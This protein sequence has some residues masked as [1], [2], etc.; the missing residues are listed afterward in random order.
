MQQRKDKAALA[1]TQTEA[2]A[3]MYAADKQY[4]A[5]VDV[6]EMSNNHE[7]EKV[8]AKTESQQQIAEKKADLKDQESFA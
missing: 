3:Q 6:K 4:A 7:P 1:K 5:K 8:A 2:K